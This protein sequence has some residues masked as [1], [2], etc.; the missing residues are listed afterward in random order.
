[1][2]KE[3]NLRIDYIQAL[4]GIAAFL[5]VIFHIG[6]EMMTQ[7]A[8]D[9]WRLLPETNSWQFGVDLFFIISGF[10]MYHVTAAKPQGPPA[11]RD[12][13]IK[14]AIRVVPV[15]WIY[16][17]LFLLP[18]T[19]SPRLLN[20]S[21]YN[22]AYIISSYAF[23]PWMRPGQLHLEPVLGVGWTLNY[24]I[25]FYILVS[26]LIFFRSKRMALHIAIIMGS[27][28]VLGYFVKES[29]VQLHYWTRTCI[30]E[31]S[32]GTVIAAI[33][34]AGHARL[35]IFAGLAVLL[36][37]IV[38][39]QVTA[40]IA[41]VGDQSINVRGYTWGVAAALIIAAI[42]LTP[43]ISRTLETGWIGRVLERVGDCSY[44]L[45]LSHLFVM[46]FATLLLWHHLHG[47]WPLYMLVTVLASIAV[48]MLSYAF[49]EKP[50]IAFSRRKFAVS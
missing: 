27:L 32:F 11:S 20:H 25:P 18:L 28:T 40:Y 2:D 21:G 23:V 35:P 7:G 43:G 37:G 36:V 9:P 42:S 33:A 34:R 19:M 38:T 24:E 15:Y 26:A 45:Y 44:S 16:T 22:L 31:F 10:I 13:L 14:R 8:P 50:I 3:A 46:R 39:W 5:V 49:I 6:K 30:L 41:P 4:R 1:M 29:D 48:A 47:A 12:F 17:T